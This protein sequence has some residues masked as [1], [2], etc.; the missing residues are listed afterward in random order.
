MKMKFW[1]RIIL[2]IGAVLT[3]LGGVLTAVCGAM[4]YGMNL[5]EGIVMQSIPLTLICKLENGTREMA[6]VNVGYAL[7]IARALGT[8]AEALFN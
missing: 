2:R 6:K 8:T 7:K 3:F 5:G 4:I 1:D